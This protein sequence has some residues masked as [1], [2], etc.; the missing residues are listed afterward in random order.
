MGDRIHKSLPTTL[1]VAT[2]YNVTL[3]SNYS[4]SQT[5][6]LNLGILH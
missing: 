2:K 4:G 3:L 5:P 1:N 6:S